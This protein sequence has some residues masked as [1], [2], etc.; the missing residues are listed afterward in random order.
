MQE[1]ISL[2]D[3]ESIAI[4]KTA[5]ILHGLF[6]TALTTSASF[7]KHVSHF[8][9][10]DIF[11]SGYKY[12]DKPLT[13][14]TG[15]YDKFGFIKNNPKNSASIDGSNEITQELLQKVYGKN[16]KACF[17][18]DI[19]SE[20]L[21][22]LISNIKEEEI[23]FQLKPERFLSMF[24]NIEQAYRLLEKHEEHY[25]VSYDNIIIARPDLAFYANLDLIKLKV[26]KVFIPGG[27]GFHPHT[28]TRIHGLVEP[29]YYKNVLNGTCIPTGLHFNDQLMAL[30][31][32]DSSILKN[33]LSDCTEYIKAR[34]PLTPET[35]LF[36]HFSVMHQLEV[37]INEKWLYEIFR[38]G[39]PEIENITNLPL[40]ER[41]DPHHPIVKR[42][43]QANKM[44]Y[45][46]KAIRRNFHYYKNRVKSLMQG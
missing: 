2:N 17:L 18:H 7:N 16:L 24:H 35:I 10:A 3:E 4:G 21:K 41:F 36:Y 22:E 20:D 12:S 8:L 26:G 37:N 30:K 25:G 46:L 6:R 31:R 44:K 14:H 33:L 43:A 13:N 40:L 29:L 27:M 42:R 11:Y 28:G 23:L 34:V 19:K 45:W 39:A 32:S 1:K 9:N 5:I 38:V 15:V